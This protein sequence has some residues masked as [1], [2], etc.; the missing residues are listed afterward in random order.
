MWKKFYFLSSLLTLLLFIQCLSMRT[1]SNNF[2]E[3]ID[4]FISQ[5]S[6]ST[7]NII[8]IRLSSFPQE[9]NILTV[10]YDFNPIMSVGKNE[11][12]IDFGQYKYKNY[13]ISFVAENGID[14]A[15]ITNNPQFNKISEESFINENGK[16]WNYNPKTLSVFFDR[17]FKYIEPLQNGVN[18]LEIDEKIKNHLKSINK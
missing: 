11:N 6:I 3:I 9:K 2:T 4:F 10:F 14:L 5:N 1:K 17:N 18:I 7:N 12:D 13:T 16:S 15:P 8:I